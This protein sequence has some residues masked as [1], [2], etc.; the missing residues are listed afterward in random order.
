[1][2]ENDPITIDVDWLADTLVA[3]VRSPSSVPRGATEVLPGDA[4]IRAAID[5][6]WLPLLASMA[7]SEVRRHPDG[8]V[9]VRFGPPGDDG[10]LVQTYVVSQHGNLM[11]DPLA[12]VLVDGEP[13]GIDGR[14]V[15]GQGANQNKG[16]AAAALAAMRAL[17]RD[18]VRPVWLAVNT[19]GRSS[20]GGSMR[21]ID[22]LGVRASSCVV[23]LGTDLA[24][25]VGNRGR[26]DVV[27]TVPG[28]S[29]HSSQPWLGDNPIDPAADV[30]RALRSA[31]L[32]L[33]DAALGPASAVPYQVHCD[34]VAP[35]TIPASATVVVDRRL[36]PGET[37]S[38][39]VRSLREHLAASVAHEVVVEE[40]AHMLP[41]TVSPDAPVVIALVEAV[42]ALTGRD[43]ADATV[44]SR[45]TFDAGLPTARGMR[46]CMFG[47][48]RRSF[49]HGVT[50]TEVVGLDDCAVAA[51]SLRRAAVALCA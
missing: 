20:H 15:V 51:E 6:T 36:L 41:S 31:P 19:E 16:P 17:P 21:I 30:V 44:M 47:P 10:L 32:P 27:V 11:D 25:S 14:C 4:T 22:E 13:H 12:G 37:P 28:T 7:P 8:D 33:P 35:H 3:L 48:G 2:T 5:D 42:R 39:A 29:C 40:G 18:L 46:T 23:S 34:P 49:S 26:V 9:A 24:V 43:P 38:D 45:N 1:M 50:G